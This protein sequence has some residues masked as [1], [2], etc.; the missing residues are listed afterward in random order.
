M[1]E[2]AAAIPN[3]AL[4]AETQFVFD[5]NWHAE[6][7]SGAPVN[8]GEG[9][10]WYENC[11]TAVHIKDIIRWLSTAKFGSS[12]YLIPVPPLCLIAGST[13]EAALPY[14]QR[15]PL[16]AGGGQF[17]VWSE[18][19]DQARRQVWGVAKRSANNCWLPIADSGLKP[20]GAITPEYTAAALAGKQGLDTFN[21]TYSHMAVKP[22]PPWESKE[23]GKKV[24]INLDR[25]LW[26]WHHQCL[27]PREAFEIS[28]LAAPAHMEACASDAPHASPY[29]TISLS[30]LELSE[31][32]ESRKPCNQYGLWRRASRP[33][34]PILTDEE[35]MQT[36]SYTSA[37]FHIQT[38]LPCYGFTTSGNRLAVQRAVDSVAVSRYRRMFGSAGAGKH[39]AGG[40]NY[41]RDPFPVWGSQPIQPPEGGGRSGRSGGGRGRGRGRTGLS[42]ALYACFR[43][44]P[45]DPI[46]EP[47]IEEAPISSAEETEQAATTFDPAMRSW[48]QAY[49]AWEAEVASSRAATP[50]PGIVGEPFS[51]ER[52]A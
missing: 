7:V 38:G 31:L 1:A 24:R 30:T 39:P 12:H 34:L 43:P 9:A 35:L 45:E 10:L 47:D 32:N 27:Y 14:P 2:L 48:W 37:C 52:V 22:T 49:E 11:F 5:I 40:D 15:L 8:A 36:A 44:E 19:P 17:G 20:Y 16:E 6:R 23:V 29:W 42:R 4:I 33:G 51:P 28:H 50:P 46:D 13:G 41:P 21:A 25:L 3:P 26:R 18:R